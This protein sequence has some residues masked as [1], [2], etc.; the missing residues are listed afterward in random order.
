MKTNFMEK[1]IV[2]NACLFLV[3]ITFPWTVV[4]KIRPESL[5]W[6]LVKIEGKV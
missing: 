1:K 3:F 6:G 2:F 4:E 5:S